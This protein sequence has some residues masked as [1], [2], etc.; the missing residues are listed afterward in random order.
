LR[1]FTSAL[2]TQ[3]PLKINSAIAIHQVPQHGDLVEWLLINKF[4]TMILINRTLPNGQIKPI[5][6]KG[7]IPERDGEIMSK[8]D[9]HEFGLAML[10][11]YLNK[12]NGKLI[13]ANNNIGN[14][15]PHLV[16]KNPKGEL[17]YIWVNSGWMDFI[18]LN[19]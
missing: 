3:E 11:V 6:H 12:Q 14:E 18:S 2:S 9:I 15:Y 16:T 1:W 10:I 5:V 19:K 4:I 8:E 7:D 17:L 13:R